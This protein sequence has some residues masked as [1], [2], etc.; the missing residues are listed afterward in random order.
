MVRVQ[1]VAAAA[2]VSVGTVSNVLNHPEKV[3]TET[4]DRVQRAIDELGFVRNDAARQL[5]NGLSLSVGLIVPDLR[6]PFFAEVA[7]G[8]DRRAREHGLALMITNSDED[9]GRELEHTRLFEQQRVSGVLASPVADQLGHLSQIRSR[10]IPVV[11]VDRVSDDGSLPAV[12]V[13]D[14][15]G[16]RLAAAHLIGQG[17]RRLAFVGGAITVRQ[18]ADR[19]AG[20]Q[21]AVL[22]A[23]EATMEVIGTDDLTVMAGRDVGAGLSARPP[24]RRPDAIFA[25]NDLLALG[26]LQALVMDG[27]ISVPGDI[28][29]VGY[30]DI[31][32]SRSAVV[33]LSSIRQ[34]AAEMGATAIDLLLEQRSQRAPRGVLYRPEL[35]VRDSSRPS[36]APG[37]ASRSE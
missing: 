30:D 34:P 32:F 29:I 11:L 14:V 21:Q 20:A 28:A 37:Q 7:R 6:N 18:I 10:G 12:A 13:D 4:V 17:R 9:A 5:R 27:S 3:A 26:L 22:A 33:S 25:A 8:A 31:D 2:R 19:L 24:E 1:D 16:G 23:P 35:V 36:A 15:E